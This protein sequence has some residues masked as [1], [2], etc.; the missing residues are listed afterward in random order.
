LFPLRHQPG[1]LTV[2]TRLD[3]LTFVVDPMRRAVFTH[4]QTTPAVAARSRAGSR[5][6]TGHVPVGLEPGPTVAFTAPMFELAAVA[7]SKTD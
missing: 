7:F 6:S 4:V 5:G 2:V 1:W 3:P